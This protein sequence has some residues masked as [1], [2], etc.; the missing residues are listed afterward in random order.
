MVLY[1]TTVVVIVVVVVLT[2]DD[3]MKLYVLHILN[4]GTTEVVTGS[5][6]VT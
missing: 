5:D 2:V 1:D 3:D 6:R 4:S